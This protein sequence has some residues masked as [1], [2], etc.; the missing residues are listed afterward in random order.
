[1]KGAPQPVMVV[2]EEPVE[3]VSVALAPLV[4]SD[5]KRNLKEVVGGAGAFFGVPAQEMPSESPTPNRSRTASK[6]NES[7]SSSKRVKQ[8]REDAPVPAPVSAEQCLLGLKI[9][10]TGVMELTGREEIES[11]ILELGGKVATN[12]SG[13][14]DILVAGDV[15]ED[16]R[17]AKES[18]K[19]KNAQ[20]KGVRILGEEEFLKFIEEKIRAAPKVTSSKPL[21]EAI[22][23]KQESFKISAAVPMKARE[24]TAIRTN[25]VDRDS[26]L[27]VDKYRPENL[28]DIIGSADIVKKLRDW[29]K[30]WEVVHIKKALKANFSKENPGAKAVLL[31]GPPGKRNFSRFG[32]VYTYATW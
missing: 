29:L 6:V 1:M 16:G 18:S 30:D 14:T 17:P 13:K 24:A 3:P 26:M 10:V 7:N 25:E 27:W 4:K 28:I 22:P 11:K 15:L 19:F 2:D 12:V 32:L 21:L 5:K 23:P 31:S 9:A 20:E 8:E